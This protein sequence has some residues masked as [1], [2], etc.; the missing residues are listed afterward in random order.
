MVV[1]ILQMLKEKEAFL[2]LPRIA[3]VKIRTS[4]K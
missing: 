2:T 1:E 3:L 4:L